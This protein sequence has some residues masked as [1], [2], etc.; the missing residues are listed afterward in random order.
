MPNDHIDGMQSHRDG[1][2]LGTNT[3]TLK[4]QGTVELWKGSNANGD[5]DKKVRGP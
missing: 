5:S 2:G 3:T 1:N 4:P